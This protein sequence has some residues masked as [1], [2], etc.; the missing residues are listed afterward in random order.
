VTNATYGKIFGADT[1]PIIFNT[2]IPLKIILLR[3]R[4]RFGGSVDKFGAATAAGESSPNCGGLKNP[5][6][7]HFQILAHG[8]GKTLGAR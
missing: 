4:R 6:G 7:N 3:D 8:Q 2:S 1:R 5:D